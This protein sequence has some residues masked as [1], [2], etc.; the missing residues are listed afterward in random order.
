MVKID[1]KNYTLDYALLLL[2]LKTE[3]TQ[4]AI[5]MLLKDDYTSKGILFVLTK[6]EVQEKLCKFKHDNRYVSIFVNEVKKYAY[7]KND[8]RWND[9]N[10][11]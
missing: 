11:R 6:N 4:K 7:K 2:D 1:Y 8:E 10:K 9:K 5:D 3:S